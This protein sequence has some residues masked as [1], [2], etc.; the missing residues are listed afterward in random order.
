MAR[1]DGERRG[2]AVW[3]LHLSDRVGHGLRGQ[4]RAARLLRGQRPRFRREWPL[5]DAL[6]IGGL[7]FVAPGGG[8]MPLSPLQ[9][10]AAAIAVTL[11]AVLLARLLMART[12]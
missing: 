7:M 1:N 6:V 4:T 8:M 2:L 9:M 12:R 11:P 10:T 3:L 5:R